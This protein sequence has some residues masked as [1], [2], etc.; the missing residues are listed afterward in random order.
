MARK[1]SGGD[2]VNKGMA[3]SGLLSWQG[4]W[5]YGVSDDG[6][7]GGGVVM[8]RDM[9]GGKGTDRVDSC[10]LCGDGGWMLSGGESVSTSSEE[11]VRSDSERE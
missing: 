11:T 8:R 1:G 5:W 4:V 2:T 6:G 7:E 9:G 3:A 10:G